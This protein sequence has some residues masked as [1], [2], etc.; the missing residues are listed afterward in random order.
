MPLWDAI[1]AVAF[2]AIAVTLWYLS[3]SRRR[4]PFTWML[5]LFGL[6]LALG[7]VWHLADAVGVVRTGALHETLAAG[8]AL[9]S[10]AAA[11]ALVRL[12]PKIVRTPSPIIDA[13][14]G[15]PNRAMIAH[16]IARAIEQGLRNPRAVFAAIFVDL[17]GFKGINDSFGHDVGDELLVAVARRLQD[18]VRSG[19]IVARLGGDEFL[20]FMDRA[21]DRSIAEQSAARIV[22][23][24]AKPFVVAGR[25]M[26]IRASAGVVFSAG[27]AD[28]RLLL[29]DADAAM[30]GAK[31]RGGNRYEVAVAK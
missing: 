3:F 14:T 6:L 18:C 31:A 4:D 5:G 10:I 2:L 27:Y 22:A 12:A 13:L 21:G 28:E 15:L 24:L 30:Y 17:D 29:R 11:A 9:M 26:S 7:G 20:V 19:D 25:P 8:V 1:T 16:R 23:E